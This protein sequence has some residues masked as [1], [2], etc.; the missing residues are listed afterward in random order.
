[1]ADAFRRLGHD[2]R[3]IGPTSGNEI[4][5]RT[6]DAK[7]VWKPDGFL[8]AHWPDWT[9][10]LILIIGSILGH[11]AFYP[12]V[13]HVVYGVDN[14]VFNY[15]QPGVEHYFIAHRTGPEMPVAGDD[16]T[17]LPA[18]YDPVH[19]TPSP[20]PWRERPIDVAL[21]GVIYP[22]RQ[23]FFD[24]IKR[25]PIKYFFGP[26]FVYD[27]YR[28]IY[29]QTRIAIS[30]SVKRDVGQRIFETAAMGCLVLT[31]DCPDLKDLQVA[32]MAIYPHE[33]AALQMIPQI[34]ANPTNA[35]KMIER[36][37]QWAKP[38]TWD[39]RGRVIIDWFERTYKK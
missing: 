17:W 23:R 4:W 37:T 9:P 14:H 15:R 13:P 5:D 32:G 36:S 8:D 20:I 19:F 22:A 39:A 1:M 12:D 3:S 27:E 6:I 18:A 2:V 24:A 28:S 25:L 30:L 11:H 34:L 16:V 7:Y 31:D 10:D 26:G 35:E 33:A 29:H 38:H 21:V